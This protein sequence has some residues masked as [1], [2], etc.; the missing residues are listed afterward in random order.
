MAATY[1]WQ[2]A[3][4]GAFDTAANWDLASVPGASDTARFFAGGGGI[5]GTGSVDTIAFRAAAWIV[6]G[7]LTAT[8]ITVDSGALGVSGG[9]AKLVATSTLLVGQSAYTTVGVSSYGR[10]VV[11]GTASGPASAFAAASL[12][13]TT[14]GI[15]SFGGS[16]MLGANAAS[17]SAVV[18]AS[19]MS[20][21]GIFQ[22]GSS[23]SASLVV[24]NGGTV[25]LTAAGN[26]GLNS[27]YLQ[28]GAAAGSSG[29]VQVN[30][31][32]SI[33]L[34]ASNGGV[35]G[36]GGS[37]VLSVASGGTVRLR[38]ANNPLDPALAIGL[39]SGSAGAVTVAN[40]GSTLAVNGTVTVGVAG[41][42]SL[43]IVGGGSVTSA[44]VASTESALSVAAAGGPGTLSIEGAGSQLV[45]SGQAVIGGDNRGGG[46]YA[47]GA[48]T[49]SISGG[50]LLQTGTLSI[51][52]GSRVSIDSV[53]REVISGDLRTFGT[54][55]SLG[56]LVVGGAVAG[57]GTLQ[58]GG[59][60]A[61]VGALAT[62]NVAFA[63][64]N[65]TLYVRGLS[66]S[67]NVSGIQYG[68]RIDLVGNTSVRLS[69]NLVTT[70][71]GTILL[72]AAPADTR[73]GL[74]SDG[75]GGTIISITPSTVGVYRF[76]DSSYGTHFFS[77]SVSEKDT[78][79]GTRPDLV[80]EG[81]GL[82]SIDPAGG[83]PNAAPVF[84]FFDST[85][86]THFFTASTSERDAVIATRSDLF[87]EGTGFIEHVT[88]QSGDTAV[89]RFFDTRF[90]THFYT[91]DANERATVID[92]RPDL[93]DEGIGF[94]APTA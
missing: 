74:S 34:V 33:L 83:D 86:G 14:G 19:V 31:R 41:S 51:F 17:T 49:V 89:Y 64:P 85:Y 32:S 28:L 52:A 45:A 76:F 38:T 23:G 12:S 54:L 27:G 13:V 53:S 8:T 57:S 22:L 5:S 48:G 68:D 50:G 2:A 65:A 81:V 82:Q 37:G 35:V 47:G 29:T 25:V 46:Y 30:G 91:A 77:S 88:P 72:G 6:V 9:L 3:G 94:Y 56:T 58:I 63:G 4:G 26:S 16:L 78:I 40:T 60:T 10:L 43:R 18:D 75:S 80:Y 84:R 24:Q 70:A 15:A 11:A 1:T 44:T 55:A 62:A 20:V 71:S 90:G 59:G 66:G 7:D 87:Y 79:I 39:L 73:Y 93:A 61:D 21:G 42:G 92:T 69:G 36:L 67:S